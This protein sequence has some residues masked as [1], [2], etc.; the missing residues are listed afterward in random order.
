MNKNLPTELDEL[1]L[2]AAAGKKQSPLQLLVWL[3]I[4]G[5]VAYG[6]YHYQDSLMSFIRRP[7]AAADVPAAPTAGGGRGR[8]GRGGGG[9]GGTVVAAMAARKADMPVYLRGLGA[10]TPFNNVTVRTRVDGQ[11]V[12]VVFKEGQVVREG[13][14]LAEIDPR[15]FEVQLSQAQAQR[16][17]ARGNLQRDMALLNGANIEQARNQ[18]LL[19]KGL[20]PKQQFDQ[21]TASVD[22]Y[23]GSIAADNAAIET[24]EA[25]IANANL[26][27]TYSKIT[28]PIS[29]RIGL[30]V[31]D[32]GNIVRAADPNGIALI[33][34]IQPITVLFNIPED[35]LPVV[36]KKLRE[37][38][39]LKVD[40]YDRDDQIKLAA[41]TLLTVDNQIDSSTGTSR[42]KAVL[43]NKDNALFP[44]QFVNIHLLLEVERNATVIPAAAIQRGPQGTYVY[45]VGSDKKAQMRPVTV[46]NTQGSDVS[47]STELKPGELVIV[48][49]MDR[50]QDGGRVDAEISQGSAASVDGAA[51]AL[52]NDS[53]RR[54][55]AGFRGQ[56]GRGQ[57]QGRG[58]RR[59]GS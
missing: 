1:A 55:G 9:P 25:A 22:Q 14:L 3:L 39:T 41:G 11:L 24:A 28:A 54:A 48:E 23:K 21:Q 10:V 59:Q 36:L 12:N 53:G 31:V 57:G 42:L 50:V 16:N 38:E 49:G 51:G 40:A 44:N 13:E 35:S 30:R 4:F 29:G 47:V 15:P 32:P 34:Q 5:A 37:G 58:V 27:I 19:E 56:G 2:T 46:K 8:G 17:Q 45:V 33:A 18:T 43:D 6:A 52:S 20:I 7:V 26:Q